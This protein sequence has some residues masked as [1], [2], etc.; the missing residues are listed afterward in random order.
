[1]GNV[2]QLVVVTMKTLSNKTKS[3]ADHSTSLDHIVSREKMT[4]STT[5]TLLPGPTTKLEPLVTSKFHFTNRPSS[6]RL[7]TI[8]DPLVPFGHNLPKT[9]GSNKMTN[10]FSKILLIRDQPSVND[11]TTP[12]THT[13]VNTPLV[14][15]SKNH[16]IL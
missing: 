11:V 12:L 3:S 6:P 5:P 1:M 10:G 4:C 13:D 7:V 14:V 2:R 16:L 9:N 15:V 8:P